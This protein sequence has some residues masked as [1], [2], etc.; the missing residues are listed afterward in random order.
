MRTNRKVKIGLLVVVFVFFSKPSFAQEVVITDTIDAE[1]V[2]GKKNITQIPLDQC[3][4][5]DTCSIKK[6]AIVTKGGKHGIYDL[7]KNENVTEIVFDVASFYRRHV[8]E[9]GIEVSYFCVEKGIE[10]GIIG[11]VGKDNQT[12]GV[13]MDN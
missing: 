5:I 2:F 3:E 9:D 1:E 12:V 13:W 11:V 6:Y 7:E 10:R 8:S 4:K